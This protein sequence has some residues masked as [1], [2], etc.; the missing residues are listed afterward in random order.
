MERPVRMILKALGLAAI[1]WAATPGATDVLAGHRGEAGGR[2]DRPPW[3]APAV[4]PSAVQ[5]SGRRGNFSARPGRGGAQ[6][7]QRDQRPIQDIGRDRRL[8]IQD[9]RRDRRLRVQDSGRDRR[10]S[11]RDRRRRGRDEQDRA[12]DAVRGGQARPLAEIITGL[13]NVCP[14]T[15][16]GAS[17]QR[18]GQG[19]LYRVQILRPSGRRITFLVDAGTGAIVSGRCR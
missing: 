4:Q 9:T 5:P 1:M 16:L 7:S 18:Q 2:R 11:R 10:R 17:L 14:G 12:R 8:R 3:S 19:Y 13:Q 15:F 6:S